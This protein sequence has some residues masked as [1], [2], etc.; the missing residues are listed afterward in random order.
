MNKYRV[1]I[2]KD[3][4]KERDRQD[5]LHPQVLGLSLRFV[6]IMEELGEVAQALQDNDMDSVYREVIEAAAT[7]VRMAE[8]LLEYEK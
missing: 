4:N 5:K 7:C 8:E 6:T 2:I 3:L 1:K